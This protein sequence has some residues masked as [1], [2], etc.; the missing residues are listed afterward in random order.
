MTEIINDRYELIEVERLVPH[1]QN[2]NQGD[3]EV[4]D[5]S[6]EV[7]GFYGA[8]TVRPHPT[9]FDR[10]EILAGEHRWRSVAA[11][12]GS[13]VPCIV[14]IADDVTAARVMLVDNEAARHATY[15]GQKLTDLLDSLGSI[16]GTGFQ[17]ADLADFE[18]ER[19]IQEAN[20]RE[21]VESAAPAVFGLL[22]LCD[23]ERDQ[24]DL[25]RELVGRDYEVKKAA[26]PQP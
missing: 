2:P 6:I 9:E 11:R 4:I 8:V 7:N 24:E 12:G 20:E 15:D 25:A 23:S 13:H 3:L 17:L 16:E 26:V 18:E 19:Q 22:V 5:E 1:P 14:V 10:F 21:I